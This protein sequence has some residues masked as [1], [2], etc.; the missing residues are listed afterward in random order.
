[1]TT[2]IVAGG[3]IAGLLAAK[4]LARKHERVLLVERDASCGGLLGSIHNDDGIN[5]D[6]GAH[7]LSETGVAEVDALLYGNLNEADWRCFNVLRAGNWF[8]G[9]M[10]RSSPFPD[11]RRLGTEALHVAL[12]ELAHAA[13]VHH[14]SPPATL[15][16]AL[17]R[18]FGPTLAS[19]VAG[20]AVRKQLGVEPEQ[21]HPLTPFA[22]RRLI[23]GNAEESRRLKQDPRFSEPLAY[24]SYEEGVGTLLHRYPRAG[25]IGQ[26]VDGFVEGLQDD[27]VEIACSR[28]I[29]AVTHSGGKVTSVTLDDGRDITCAMLAWTLPAAMLLRAASIPFES[30]PPLARPIGLFHLVFDM[31]FGDPNYHVTC[32]D[33][34]LHTFRVTLYPNLR[35]QPQQAP[36]NCTVEVIGNTGADFSA[37]LPQVVEE[38][39]QMGI[40]PS[41]A[42]LVSSMVRVVPMGFPATTHELMATNAALADRAQEHLRN[43]ELL[44]RARCPPFFT[45]DVLIEVYRKL[46][47]HGNA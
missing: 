23:C 36:Y 15:A 42:Q 10:N 7:V 9:A 30:K 26:W 8:G 40:T 5:F 46:S 44:G 28:T 25:G 38:L 33:E 22:I 2:A 14:E 27:G 45:T 6:H 41:S 1:M 16:E 21:L 31:P 4:L 13:S 37:L 3:G 11:A 32:Y 24:A 43:V 39:K 29:T 20:P 18:R 35:D 12:D 19:R 17:H 34:A 47:K